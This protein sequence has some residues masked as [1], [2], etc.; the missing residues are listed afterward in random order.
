[1]ELVID[2]HRVVI[3]ADAFGATMKQM[4]AAE[5]RALNKTVNWVRSK[6]VRSVAKEMKVAAKLVRQRIA[7]FKATRRKR[8]GKVWAG[9]KPIAAHRL[10]KVKQTRRGVRAGRHSFTGA[11]AANT[12]RGKQ[13]VFQRTG[14]PKRKMRTGRYAG[15]MRE[16]IELVELELD[17]QK[18]TDALEELFGSAQQRFFEVFKQ[19]L[20]YQ[21]FVKNAR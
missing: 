13:A 10:G 18:V 2:T 20:K 8:Y 4:E 1:M 15:K 14:E 6:A 11:F 12:G 5:V 16:P 7:A 21:V 17:Q 19:E 3:L 9:L